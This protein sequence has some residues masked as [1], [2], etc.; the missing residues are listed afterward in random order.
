MQKNKNRNNITWH[1]ISPLTLCKYFGTVKEENKEY[2][3]TPNMSKALKTSTQRKDSIY[4]LGVNAIKNSTS[5]GKTPKKEAEPKLRAK[6]LSPSG[7]LS[8]DLNK[9]GKKR[10]QSEINDE[11]N[12]KFNSKVSSTEF[13]PKVQ[14][15]VA[16]INAKTSSQSQRTSLSPTKQPSIDSKGINSNQQIINALSQ[17]VQ[18]MES[19]PEINFKPSRDSDD[20]DDEMHS[21][22]SACEF[23]SNPISSSSTSSTA[24]SATSSSS[25]DSNMSLFPNILKTGLQSKNLIHG[26]IKLC[27]KKEN[28]AIYFLSL[29]V[30][31]TF[32][33]LM[34]FLVMFIFML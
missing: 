30:L 31:R 4:P 6:I 2:K 20:I 27:R 29:K 26:D 7:N 21:A 8:K 24:I 9:S 16:E 33:S 5:S 13:V 23:D 3:K 17:F 22:S 32:N 12:A 18:K 15:I 11:N 34:K 28:I 19:E 1:N 25:S 14:R 10:D